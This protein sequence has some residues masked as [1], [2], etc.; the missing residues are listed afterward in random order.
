MISK[1]EEYNASEC[2]V[3]HEET[4]A[5]VCDRLPEDEVIM[6]LADAFKAFSDFTRLK[7]LL[8]LLNSEMCVCDIAAVLGM[9]KSAVSHQLKTLKQNNLVR[10][11]REGKVI[12]YSIADG[13]VETMISNGME[14]VL[15]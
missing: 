13:H 9:T 7:I 6:D 12:Y 5:A 14:H 4:V 8:A 15:E 1:A 11:R 3:I 10:S 2:S